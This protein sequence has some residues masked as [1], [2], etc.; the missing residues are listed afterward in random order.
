M[1]LALLLP[2]S[3]HREGIKAQQCL[4]K[5]SDFISYSWWVAKLI[6]LLYFLGSRNH[7]FWSL[8]SQL[9]LKSQIK[10]IL[11]LH[12]PLTFVT[13]NFS[14]SICILLFRLSLL[15]S[16]FSSF[17]SQSIKVRLQGWLAGSVG[18]TCD[19]W[20]QCCEFEPH[21]VCRCC[22]KIKKKKKVR[23]RLH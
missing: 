3:F 1:A 21:V 20:S 17:V 8:S 11:P 4:F 7:D 9:L 12:I 13:G 5:L 15:L 16:L 6:F 23:L 19:S 10:Y 22:L 2:F 14:H 18:G